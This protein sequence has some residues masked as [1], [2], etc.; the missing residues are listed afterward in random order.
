MSCRW[1]GWSGA[2]HSEG[3]RRR[4]G[5]ENELCLPF[6]GWM[7]QQLSYSPWGRVGDQDCQIAS[8][9]AGVRIHNKEAIGLVWY[10]YMERM[11][12]GAGQRRRPSVF[13][14]R[15]RAFR[16]RVVSTQKTHDFSFVNVEWHPRLFTPCL[17]CVYYH[18]ELESIG[19]I[20]H[21]SS[22]YRIPPIHLTPLLWV[23]VALGNCILSS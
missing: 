13:R 14:S 8:P 9:L 17:T 22:T 2:C 20:K 5:Q 7:T 1:W 3:N 21:R 16:A 12:N 23:I 19:R 10:A 18:L 6:L 4:R 15:F 11:W